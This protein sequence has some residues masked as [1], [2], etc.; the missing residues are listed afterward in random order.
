MKFIEN[1]F[2]IDSHTRAN[3]QFFHIYQLFVRFCGLSRGSHQDQGI[4]VFTFCRT[5]SS[6]T[7]A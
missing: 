3:A 5:I 4:Q 7:I 1:F 2:G 6:G